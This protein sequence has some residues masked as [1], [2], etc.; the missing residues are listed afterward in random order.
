MKELKELQA[1]RFDRERQEF[2]E[3][4]RSYLSAKQENKPFDP[5]E[6][7]F[8]FSTEEIERQIQRRAALASPSRFPKAA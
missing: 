1:E 4:A 7:G 8:E 2:D 5:I 6:F 3:A